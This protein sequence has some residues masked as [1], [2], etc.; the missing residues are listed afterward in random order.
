[1]T[2]PPESPEPQE[3]PSAG[4]I[5]HVTTNLP[6]SNIGWAV[7]SV[8]FFWP[9]AFSAF[10]NAWKVYPLWSAGDTEGAERAAAKAKLLGKISL[11]VGLVLIFLLVALR[12]AAF[13]FCHRHGGGWG[14]HHG[15]WGHGD[16]GHGDHDRGDWGHDGWDRGD[17]GRWGADG[18]A[19]PAPPERPLPPAQPAPPERP[20]S[21]APPPPRM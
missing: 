15:G 11:L 17:H 10:A 20:F 6:Q 4:T 2:E 19:Q 13:W 12:I 7:A 1:M 3:K 14:H 9:L 16:W 8:V 5:T 18:P 21:P